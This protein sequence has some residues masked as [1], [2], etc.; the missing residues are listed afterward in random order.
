MNERPQTRAILPLCVQDFMRSSTSQYFATKPTLHH[1]QLLYVITF[2]ITNGI[3]SGNKYV[4][5]CASLADESLSQGTIVNHKITAICHNCKHLPRLLKT[6]FCSIFH[7][8]VWNSYSRDWLTADKRLG[9]IHLLLSF[10]PS[11]EED[12]G[13]W[14]NFYLFIKTQSDFSA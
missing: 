10:S 14:L 9:N 6:Q 11:S 12:A 5:F 4:N 2:I 7:Q 13:Y 8:L 3:N 1:L